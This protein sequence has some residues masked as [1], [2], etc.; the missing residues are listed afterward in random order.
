MLA[1]GRKYITL[2]GDRLVKLEYQPRADKDEFRWLGTI[3]SA[4]TGKTYQH[5]YTDDGQWSK[6]G[7]S[8]KD[9]ILDSGTAA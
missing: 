3:M 2:D 6:G 9:L 4:K 1:A 8:E 5:W 7:W